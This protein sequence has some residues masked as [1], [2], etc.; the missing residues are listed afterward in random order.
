[1]ETEGKQEKKDEPASQQEQPIEGASE[2]RDRHS[3]PPQEEKVDEARV[4]AALLEA[5]ATEMDLGVPADSSPAASDDA[6][7]K[8]ASQPTSM[9]PPR[10][11]WDMDESSED[12][13]DEGFASSSPPI[14]G[15]LAE[16]DVAGDLALT[17]MTCPPS[18]PTTVAP[19]ALSL[20]LSMSASRDAEVPQL[21]TFDSDIPQPQSA[22]LLQS[23]P[24]PFGAMDVDPAAVC[25]VAAGS[26]T[27]TSD[28]TGSSPFDLDDQQDIEAAVDE[29]GDTSHD[30]Q[31]DMIAIDEESLSALEKI[32]ICAKSDHA[33]ER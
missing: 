14:T 18:P 3:T 25:S 22:H 5:E 21:R 20:S 4:A 31:S 16:A 8:Q 27:V 12:E 11:G 33:D 26:E 30:S 29:G 1:M 13:L 32:F 28:I 9:S 6:S 7:S 23:M 24:S 10:S 19:S 17:R 2:S 15:R